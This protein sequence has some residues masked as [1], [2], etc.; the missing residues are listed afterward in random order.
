MLKCT[1]EA[2]GQPTILVS[3]SKLNHA[4]CIV[5]QRGVIQNMASTEDGLFEFALSAL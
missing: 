4:K 5:L 1:H 3:C 2:K